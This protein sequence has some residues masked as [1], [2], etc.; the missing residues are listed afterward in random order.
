MTIALVGI[1]ADDTLWH[2]EHLYAD[3]RARFREILT[4][5]SSAN[6]HGLPDDLDDIIQLIEVGNLPYYGYGITSFVMSL[7]ETAVRVTDGRVSGHELQDVLA[8]AKQMMDA[9]VTLLDGVE[10]A[11]VELSAAHSLALITKGDLLQQQGK[12]ARSGIA[13]YFDHVEVVS[14]KTPDT[15]A[16]L[17]AR[18]HVAPDQ[19][20]MAGNS[21]RSDVLPVLELGG[22]GIY[23]PHDL[24]WSHEHSEPPGADHQRFYEL[25]R[26]ADLPALLGRMQA[27]M[28]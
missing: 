13:H 11:L 27:N 14:N 19:F 7:M 1:D 15:Y 22:Y 6:G 23:V 21:L 20:V 28:A 12:I 8:I 9:E 10:E 16:A 25:E 5:S 4:A 2:N 24:T 18:W 17:L 26:L 3:A